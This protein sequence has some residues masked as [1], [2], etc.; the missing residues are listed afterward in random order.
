[1]KRTAFVVLL[2]LGC[3]ARALAE[4]RAT[5]C[6]ICHAKPEIGEI[7]KDSAAIVEHEQ[8]GAHAAAGLSCHDCHGGNPDPALAADLSAMDSHD[9]AAPYVGAPKRADI[10]AFCGRCHSDPTRMKRFK[11]DMRVDQERE[12]WT[13]RH[14]ELL[15]TGDA[16]VATC[17]DCHGTH[18]ILAPSDT[19]SPVHP[20]RVADTCSRCHSDAARMASY[21]LP[22]GRSLP[23]DQYARWRHSV[24]A[25]SLLERED[26]S[27]PTCNDCHGNHGATP[28]GIES[29][30]LV[31]GQCHGREAELFRASP[32]AAG[33]EDHRQYMK[34]AGK[35]GCVSCHPPPSPAA[36]LGTSVTFAQCETC[37]G[38]HG[39]VRPT[40][41]M[42]APLPPAP[43]DFCHE[44]AGK[45]SA[46]VEAT[47]SV[48]RHYEETRAALL[49]EATAKGLDGAARFDW[50]VDRA[51]E[52]PAHRARGAESGG[53]GAL[54]P[55]FERL[56]TKF[57][58]GKSRYAYEHGG[59]TVGVEVVRCS[60]CHAAGGTT[61]TVGPETATLFIDD[62]RRLTSATARAERMLLA[63]RRGGVE[64][65]KVTPH[66]DAAVTAQIE[67]EVLVHT[68]SSAADGKFA[69]RYRDGMARAESALAGA[70]E[71]LDE[72]ASRRR[73]L[74]VFLGFLVLVLVAMVLKIRDLSR[75]E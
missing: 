42:L 32:K 60:D 62:M 24:H 44:A 14:G 27:A 21:R 18:G 2:L 57:R 53:G 67:L 46:P 8:N 12:Y 61:D 6:T 58:I 49:R 75:E 13:S 65:R 74:V 10:P 40:V 33:F 26:L 30:A 70:R 37:H 25:Q 20:Q 5:S 55:E 69:I 15:K 43:C 35:A 39:I 66:I 29:V 45:G 3:G 7:V 64:L 54:G 41:A 71:A 72:L 1:M 51:L 63:A 9:S 28:P 23:V 17:V 56:F 4:Q 36:T 68:F 59:E 50:L 52:I 31:C 47:A 11:P 34:E 38:N 19:Q 73:G 22:D 48:Q 16:N